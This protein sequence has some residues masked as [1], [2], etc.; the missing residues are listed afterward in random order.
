MADVILA[1][2]GTDNQIRV[3]TRSDDLVGSRQVW[4]NN[5]L[6]EQHA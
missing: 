4:L 1:F 5:A 2:A 3:Y 6:I